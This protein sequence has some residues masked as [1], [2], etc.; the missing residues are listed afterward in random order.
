MHGRYRFR[1]IRP[2]AHR[3][4]RLWHRKRVR[5]LVILKLVIMCGLLAAYFLPPTHAMFVAASANLL[6]LWRT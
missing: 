4:T 2:A 1:T 6:W 5:Q 3:R